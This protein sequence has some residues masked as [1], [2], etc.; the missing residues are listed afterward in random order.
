MQQRD[1]LAFVV[2]EEFFL[3]ACGC[4]WWK[5]RGLGGEG[6]RRQTFIVLLMVGFWSECEGLDLLLLLSAGG[7]WL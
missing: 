3:R 6:V 5:C 1:D 7:K 2:F 4:W